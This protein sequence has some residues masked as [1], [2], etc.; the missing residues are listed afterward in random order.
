MKALPG[1]FHKQGGGERFGTGGENSH[2]MR[3]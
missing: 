1:A 2:E 3:F